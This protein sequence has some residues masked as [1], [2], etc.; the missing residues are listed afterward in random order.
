MLL[1]LKQN[2]SLTESP[3]NLVNSRQSLLKIQD[4]T[5]H[6][7]YHHILLYVLNYVYFKILFNKKILFYDPTSKKG[8][9]LAHPQ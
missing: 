2:L 8:K 6:C 5:W 9:E 1:L 7:Y 3:Q 4:N